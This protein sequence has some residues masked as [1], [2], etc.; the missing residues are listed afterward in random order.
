MIKTIIF[1]LGGEILTLDQPEAI[2]RFKELGVADAEKHLDAYTQKGIFG[3]LERGTITAEE[4][5]QGLSQLTG[6][7]MT[8]EDCC[9]GWQG[10]A[11]E[12]PQRNID[13]LRRLR[14]EGYRLVLL[15]NTNP[16]MMEWVSSDAFDGGHHP[17]EYYMDALYL[18]YEMKVMKPDEQFFLRVLEAERLLPEHALFIDDGAR[19]VEAASR[20]GIRTFSP[21]NGEDWTT[22]IDQYLT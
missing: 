20:L 7:E 8:H 21:K 6:R 1:D 11:K 17:I 15:S 14:A 2:R 9:Y 19:N 12:V 4:F 10:Y 3:D 16:Y 5:R 22:M 13:L 18:S